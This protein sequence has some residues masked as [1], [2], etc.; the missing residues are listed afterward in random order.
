MDEKK[1]LILN[2]SKGRIGEDASR[3]LG[4]LLI[5]KIQLAAMQRVNMPE[6]ER[7]DF[8]LYVDEFQNFATESFVNIL[9]EA[10]KYR[11]CLILGHQY[12]SQMEETV[13]D[14]VF[15]NVGTIISFRVG[16]ED[17]EYLEKE[18]APEFFAE[19]LVNL[20][21]Y[22]IYLKLM[23]DGL[24]GRPFSGET[25][26][27]F[28]DPEKTNREKIIKVSRERYS[29][30]QKVVEEKITRWTE[31]LGSSDI[32]TP[33][34]AP[35]PTLYDAQCSKCGKLIK[36]PFKPDPNRPV[37]CK[38][39]LKEIKKGESSS[40]NQSSISSSPDTSHSGA[41]GPEKGLPSPTFSFN[42][43]RSAIKPKKEVSLEG[44]RKALEES[45]K[46]NSH[47]S[48]DSNNKDKIEKK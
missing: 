10:R 4:S 43:K 1:I 7:K 19:D 44:L 23:I 5:T 28:P 2:L 48:K 12:I 45:L 33:I 41:S 30:S 35:A 16:A 11:L 36:V 6:E 34:P 17:A 42:Q 9:S 46:G 25:L 14:A 13:R 47:S 15:G 22:N 3:L 26:F 39:C 18:F 37:Y 40:N 29:T 21:K 24:A 20:A 27:P 8:Y 38:S 32:V 31:N